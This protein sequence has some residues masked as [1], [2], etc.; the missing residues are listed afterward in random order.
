VDASGAATKGAN[1][2]NDQ[3]SEILN[4]IK[5]KSIQ[6][7]KKVLKNPISLEGIKETEE[8][9]EIA[10]YGNFDKQIETNFTIVRGLAYYDGFCVETNLNFKVN[11]PKGKEIDIGSIASGGRYDKLISRFKGAD[12]SG[13]GMSIGVDRLL[14]AISQINQIEVKNNEPILICILE[15]KLL[16]NYY[17]ILNQ[18]R[19]NGIN[20]ELYLDPSKNLKK[21]LTYADK[22]GCPIAII[23]GE[24]EIKD[25]KIT[26]KKLTSTKENDQIIVSKENLINEIKKII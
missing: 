3:A 1:L 25:N 22:R 5:I 24:N 16:P 10:S 9:L 14:F 18:L 4:F 13:T 21:Q 26:L 7:L 12:F 11:N 23:M 6:D 2:S 15:E 17:L 20:S 19:D 8:L